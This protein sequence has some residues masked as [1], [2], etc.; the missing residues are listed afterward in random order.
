MGYFLMRAGSSRQTQTNTHLTMESLTMIVQQVT[1]LSRGNEED[2]WTRKLSR[3]AVS[4]TPLY[5][6]YLVVTCH[7]RAAKKK[8]KSHGKDLITVADCGY[9]MSLNS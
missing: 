4:M 1:Q 2:R 6:V 8:T 5:T 9:N 3:P 7:S